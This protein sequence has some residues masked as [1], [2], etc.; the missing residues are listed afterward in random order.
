[1]TDYIGFSIGGDLLCLIGCNYSTSLMT[2][3]IGLS[4]LSILSVSNHRFRLEPFLLSLTKH[5]LG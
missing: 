4:I 3:F 5:D 2:D 1:M